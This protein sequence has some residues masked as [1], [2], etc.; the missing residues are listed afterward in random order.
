MPPLKVTQHGIILFTSKYQACVDF[1]RNIMGLEVAYS[2][3]TLTCFR[4]GS[5]YLMVET[6]GIASDQEK[7]RTQSSTVLRFDVLN[8]DAAADTLES[9]GIAVERLAFDWGR[10][11]VFIDPDGNRCELKQAS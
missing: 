11:G 5:A 7:G 1:Y 3:D 10:I 2:K 8:L 9:H 4:L 6:G